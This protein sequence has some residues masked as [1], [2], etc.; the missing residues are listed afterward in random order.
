MER[1]NP[2]PTTVA[3]ILLPSRLDVGGIICVII[4]FLFVTKQLLTIANWKKKYQYYDS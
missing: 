2:P 1:L 3:Q 4:F